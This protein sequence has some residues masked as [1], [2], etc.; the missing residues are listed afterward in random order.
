MVCFW[1][2]N[3]TWPV[4][5]LEGTPE[6]TSSNYVF[7]YFFRPK[8]SSSILLH[9]A[10]ELTRGENLPTAAVQ[11]DSSQ[12]TRCSRMHQ[13]TL[14][15][16]TIDLKSLYF[17]R[18]FKSNTLIIIYPSVGSFTPHSVNWQKPVAAE[19]LVPTKFVLDLV[20]YVKPHYKLLLRLFYLSECGVMQWPEGIY[21]LF[22]WGSTGWGCL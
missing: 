5:P 12:V 4:K 22:A 8:S 2:C 19:E 1:L 3:K 21:T 7:C 10:V 20:N 17:F 13:T 14:F 9:N 15:N 18:F 11:C 16:C 6:Y